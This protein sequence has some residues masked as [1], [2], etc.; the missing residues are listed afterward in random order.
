MSKYTDV[1]KQPWSYKAEPFEV[2][3]NVYYVGNKHVSSYL[4]NTNI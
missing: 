4:L 1:V 2:I 3:D